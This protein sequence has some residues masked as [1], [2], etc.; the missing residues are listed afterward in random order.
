MLASRCRAAMAET[1]LPIRREIEGIGK[2]VDVR[3]YLVS[4]EV[5]GDEARAGLSRAG[6]SGDIVTLDV[7]VSIL[8]S[9]AAKSSE[10]AAVI[11]GDATAAPPHRAIRLELWGSASGARVSPLDLGPL[12]LAREQARERAAQAKERAPAAVVADAE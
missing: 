7:V 5:G 8:G 10:V 9:G 2:I 3:K 1:T 12:R 6:L 11:L 4:A